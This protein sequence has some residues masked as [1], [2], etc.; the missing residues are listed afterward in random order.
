M[1]EVLDCTC[2]KGV[3]EYEETFMVFEYTTYKCYLYM[4]R[5]INLTQLNLT[6]VVSHLSDLVSWVLAQQVIQLTFTT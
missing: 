4:S 2:C 5:V 1:D 3:R 6:V